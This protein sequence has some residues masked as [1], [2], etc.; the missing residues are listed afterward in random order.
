[1][2]KLEGSSE[3]LD[4]RRSGIETRLSSGFNELRAEIR[5]AYAELRA[6]V[7]SGDAKLRIEMALLH[8]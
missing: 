6:E 3:Q 1:M 4:K 2:A 8:E 5:G 7:R